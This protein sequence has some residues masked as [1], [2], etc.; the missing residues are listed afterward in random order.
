M[1][2]EKNYERAGKKLISHT[3]GERQR[4]TPG[5]QQTMHDGAVIFSHRE[6]NYFVTE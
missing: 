2:G 6:N 5:A 4:K 3:G 1:T